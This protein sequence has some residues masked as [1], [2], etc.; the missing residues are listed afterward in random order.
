MFD[1]TSE[2]AQIRKDRAI[3][4]RKRYAKSKLDKFKFEV[5]SL[6]RE[7]ASLADIQIFLRDKKLVVALSSIQRYLKKHE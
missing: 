4:K 5:L 6:R 3:R 1:A 2:L 7:G